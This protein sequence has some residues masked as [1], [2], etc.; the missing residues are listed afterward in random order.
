M[1][2]NPYSVALFGIGLGGLV[3][4]LILTVLSGGAII[5]PLGS[6]AGW[7]GTISALSMIAFLAVEARAWQRRREAGA[8]AESKAEV[9]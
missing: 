3:L 6:F 7:L 4:A 2:Q 1:K 5:S 9:P 8:S